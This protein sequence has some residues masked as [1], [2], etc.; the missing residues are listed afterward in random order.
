[1]VLFLLPTGRPGRRLTGE[2]DEATVAGSLDLFLL[3]R[4]RTRP[5]L[6]TDALMFRCDPPASAMETSAGRK[7][8]R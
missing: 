4:G 6:S 2:D 8:P 7:N 5:R 1:L 3:L